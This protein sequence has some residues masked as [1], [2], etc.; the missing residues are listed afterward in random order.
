[1]SST[2]WYDL[3][4]YMVLPMSFTSGDHLF[5]VVAHELNHASQYAIDSLEDDAFFEHTAVF[6]EQRVAHFVPEYGV[7]IPDYQAHPDRAINYLQTDFYEYGASLWLMFLS[8]HLDDGGQALVQRL[9]LESRQPSSTTNEPDH[10]DVL[11]ALLAQRGED[12]PQFFATF[13]AWRYFTGSRD[14]GLHFKDAALWGTASEVAVSTV[15]L[16]RPEVIE[17]ALAAFGSTHRVFHRA[18]GQFGNRSDAGRSEPGGCGGGAF[19]RRQSGWSADHRSPWSSADV[20]SDRRLGPTR[21]LRAHPCAARLRSRLEGL[22]GPQRQR[23][24]ARGARGGRCRA[25]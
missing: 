12:L 10:L 22:G 20:G 11:A 1:M 13:G 19:T 25:G 24:S 23:L 15:S 17:A 3:T 8:E 9:W 18:V 5:S 16:D 6:V 14:D 7:G 4:S 2:V 21:P